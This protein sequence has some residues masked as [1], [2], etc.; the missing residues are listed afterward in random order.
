MAKAPASTKT[1]SPAQAPETAATRPTDVAGPDTA[2]PLE[3]T[4]VAAVSGPGNAVATLS[5]DEMLYA[6]SGEG[7]E[8]VV[9][10]DLAMPFFKLAQSISNEV[11]QTDPAYIRGLREG[12]WFDV[13]S[14][15]YFD[16]ITFVPCK[17]ITKYVEW[18]AE[19][20]GVLI[21][22][23]GKDDTLFL[24]CHRDEKTGLNLT[25]GGKTIVMATAT[26]F[27][28]VIVATRYGEIVK[29]DKR[30][31]VK[32][33]DEVY[34]GLL[35]RGVIALSSTQL[36]VSR[37]WITDATS[38]RVTNKTTGKTFQPPLY[39]MSYEIGSAPTKNDQ[40]SWSLATV[41][42]AGWTL[43]YPHGQEI[44]AEAQKFAKLASE[45]RVVMPRDDEAEGGGDNVPSGNGRHAYTANNDRNRAARDAVGADDIP[46]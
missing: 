44:F 24:Q 38:I 17:F 2:A 25:P 16:K 6:A 31:D 21:Q 3:N 19:K 35:R 45:M 27:G 14:K 20:R 36:K 15:E 26:W 30:Q 13:I 34:T 29:N 46:F 8:D 12:Q 9:G 1:E 18:D 5:A 10:T 42:R 37:R 7:F 33:D 4:A 32:L 23:H 28:I 41:S 39:A 40:G 22:D 43:D 11:K